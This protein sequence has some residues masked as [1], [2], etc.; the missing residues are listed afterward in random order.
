MQTVTIPQKEYLQLKKEI[1][2][3]KD[4]QF[5][6]KVDELIDILFQEKYSL[7]LTDYTED[8]T[9]HVVN[10]VKDWQDESEWDHV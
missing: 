2:L 5:L 1:E 4:N 7:I 3:L 9:E 6:K 8:L 10:K